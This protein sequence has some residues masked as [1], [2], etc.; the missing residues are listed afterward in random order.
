MYDDIYMEPA[1]TGLSSAIGALSWAIIIAFYLYF[2]FMHY[3]I[4]AYKTGDGSIAWWAFI[5][6]LNTL[7]LIK[8]AEKPMWWFFILII[9]FVNVFAFFILWMEVAKLCGQSPVWGFLVLI[10]LLNIVAI[11]VLAYGSRPIEYVEP[12][13][14]S[15]QPD[16]PVR[17]G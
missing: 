14:A 6:I 17:T 10:P 13:P 11:F 1:N 8:M 12:P 2:T 4:A 3:R 9:P 16:K 5:P 15:N 7:L